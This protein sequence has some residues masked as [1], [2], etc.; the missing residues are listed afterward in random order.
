[1]PGSV[2]RQARNA[3]DSLEAQQRAGQA[4]IDLFARPD[5]S[6]EVETAAPT[7]IALT[8]VSTPQATAHAAVLDALADV[9]PDNLSPREAL[10]ALYR[11]KA[12]AIAPAADPS[13]FTP[14]RP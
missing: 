13:T 12:L 1:M 4:Q 8:P 6:P 5:V 3:L 14:S 2:L 11:L 7:S 9:E 10:A